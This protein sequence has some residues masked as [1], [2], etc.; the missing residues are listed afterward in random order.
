MLKLLYLLPSLGWFYF[1]PSSCIPSFAL[2]LS[3]VN[4]ETNECM[5]FISPRKVRRRTLDFGG[6][7]DDVTAT[8]E[9]DGALLNPGARGRNVAIL[10]LDKPP[11]ENRHG[12]KALKK[13]KGKKGNEKEQLTDL[14]TEYYSPKAG[15]RVARTRSD[16]EDNLAIAAALQ[17]EKGKKKK[18]EKKKSKARQVN[19]K[20]DENQ[21]KDAEDDVKDA[22]IS[23]D[24]AKN[25][26]NKV[27]RS[28]AQ[29]EDHMSPFF[30]TELQFRRRSRVQ[31]CDNSA[32]NSPLKN[33]ANN[34]PDKKSAKSA[35]ESAATV[36]AADDNS[37]EVSNSAD[38]SMESLGAAD[39]SAASS[40]AADISLEDISSRNHF[41]D[42]E[43]KNAIMTLHLEA[44]LASGIIARELTHTKKKED[45]K[46]KEQEQPNEEQE[47]E[48][49][50]K[51]QNKTKSK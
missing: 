24:A 44:M 21:G 40:A 17:K 30:S 36:T 3:K 49:E 6:G 47:Q 39:V 2:S 28:L 20:E 42:K 14:L 31:Y 48:V 43:H 11:Q 1:F 33:A 13:T 23:K 9:S 10:D 18:P 22:I 15:K 26:K 25:Q 5:E 4:L 12:G 19:E 46:Q 8:S 27:P 32:E 38:V 37:A 29:L 34:S 7:G 45:S 50:Q 51:D 41:K 16:I 35:E